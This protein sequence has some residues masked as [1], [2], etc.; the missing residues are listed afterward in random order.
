MRNIL[1]ILIVFIGTGCIAQVN[2]DRFFT[3]NSMRVDLVIAGD[4]NSENIYFHSIKK[5]QFWGGSKNS[6][7]D[8]FDY[9]EFTYK[10]F[11]KESGE[12][13]FSG[14][15]CNLFN[16]WQTIEEA[17]KIEK[18][19]F[20][21]IVFP[22]PQKEIELKIF[23]R[24]RDGKQNQVFTQDINPDNYFINPEKQRYNYEKLVYNGNP[25]K[26]V[27]LVFIA[28]GYSADEME[29]FKNDSKKFADFLF[30]QKPF[31]RFK[32]EFNIWIVES[33]SEEA[34]TD[35]PGYNIYKR[36]VVNS[37]FYTFDSERYLMS[38][39]IFKIRDI[40][41]VVPYDDICVLV[42]TDKYGGGGYNYHAIFSVDNDYSDK[43]F[44]HEFGHSFAGLGDEYYYANDEEFYNL[45]IEP[46]EPNLTTLV[47]FEKKWK[48]KIDEQIPIP[49]P[50]EKDYEKSI[51]VFEGGGYVNKGMYSPYMDCRM[52]TNAAD[53]FCPVC[54]E[55]IIKM[56][57]FKIK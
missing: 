15:F 56:I 41:S 57:Q 33:V 27:D 52:K 43:V 3:E 47:D 26:K 22:F 40:A 37:S 25:E 23:A 55:A 34:G 14:G 10:V 45:T 13:I 2:Y 19:F 31:D 4:S 11:D 49:T 53:Q 46:W 38:E 5:E 39:D 36:T 29:K 7:L 12:L 9:G 48:D 50:R 18:S 54:Q 24:T 20:Q 42:N 28:E 51:G 1:L 32:D 16:E 21:T 35:I 17:T 8:V 6:L 30:S 44:V